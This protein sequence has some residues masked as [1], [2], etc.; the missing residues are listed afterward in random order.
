[1]ALLDRIIKAGSNPG[2]MML[3]PFCGCATALVA[4]ERLGRQWAG[5]DLSLL[6]TKLV[7]ERILQDN[8]P[9]GGT[10]ERMEAPIRTDVKKLPH[11]R[12]EA[13]RLYGE[14]E[15][16]CACCHTHFPFRVMD[17]D[18]IL[19]KSRGGTDHPTTCNC[20]VPAATGVRTT[21]A[22]RNGGQ[23]SAQVCN[24]FFGGRIG[25]RFRER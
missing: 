9:W 11:Y 6:A 22:W 3:G 1:M 17:V 25:A 20:C 12:E 14:Q 10:T 24:S 23:R 18:H 21:R 19:P 2:D 7:K 15:G 13:H 16:V 5:I 4:A 8:P